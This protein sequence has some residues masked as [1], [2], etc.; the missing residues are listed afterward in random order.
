MWSNGPITSLQSQLCWRAI[1]SI[2]LWSCCE[3]VPVM[4]LLPLMGWLPLTNHATCHS[5]FSWRDAALVLFHWPSLSW[6]RRYISSL[7]LCLLFVSK[8]LK[9]PFEQRPARSRIQKTRAVAR[10]QTADGRQS[11]ERWGET[12]IGPLWWTRCPLCVLLF[13]CG[14]KRPF[15]F[16][17]W[18]LGATCDPWP[19]THDPAGL[20]SHLSPPGVMVS[21]LLDAAPFFLPSCQVFMLECIIC[22]INEEDKSN[23]FCAPG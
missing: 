11:R 22:C 20:T 5:H 8:W 14:H 3:M 21:V 7:F 17:P 9:A 10:R 1:L 19:P 18:E 4:K 13:V 23:P 6:Q 12:E 2:S 15:T 16:H